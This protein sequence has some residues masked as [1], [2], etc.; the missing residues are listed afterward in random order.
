MFNTNIGNLLGFYETIL[1]QEYN[2]SPNPVYNLSFGII[3][4]EC[5]VAKGRIFKG[6]RSGIIHDFTMDVDPGYIYIEKFRGNIQWYMMENK[7]VISS[8]SFKLKNEKTQLVPFNGPS[9][10]FRLSIKEI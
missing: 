9:I 5:D 6:S 3:F 10:S 1:W 8:V 7:D 4:V 2:L